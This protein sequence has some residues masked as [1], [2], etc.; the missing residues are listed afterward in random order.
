MKSAP[1]DS[2][3]MEYLHVVKLSVDEF[4]HICSAVVSFL[5]VDIYYTLVVIGIRNFIVGGNWN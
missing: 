1:V 2:L 4:A 5:R 3:T